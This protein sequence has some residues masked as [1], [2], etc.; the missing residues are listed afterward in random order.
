MVGKSLMNCKLVF[1]E[2]THFDMRIFTPCDN[3]L[4]ISLVNGSDCEYLSAVI[5]FLERIL[6]LLVK[7]LLLIHRVMD[8]YLVS[9]SKC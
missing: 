9:H 6:L 8:M 7:H 4:L 1:L 2:E 5:T 3:K